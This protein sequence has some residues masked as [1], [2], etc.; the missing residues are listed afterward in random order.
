MV[1]GPGIQ[2]PEALRPESPTL[3]G[4]PG[5]QP[6]GKG[7]SLAVSGRNFQLRAHGRQGIYARLAALLDARLHKCDIIDGWDRVADWVRSRQYDP[8]DINGVILP[9]MLRY[10]DLDDVADLRLRR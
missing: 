5:R 8:N 9:G 2:L 4:H 6:E 7:K 1:K 10:F 3:S